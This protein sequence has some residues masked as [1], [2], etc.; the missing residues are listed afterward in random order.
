MRR[1]SA[2]AIAREALRGH[3]GWQRAWASPPEPKRRYKAIVVGGG[4]HG[5]A[6]GLLS[7]PQPRHHG[8]GDHREGMDRRRQHRAQHHHH[9]LELPPGRLRR[10]LREGPLALRD[11]EPGTQLQRHVQPPRRHDAGPDPARGPRLQAHRHGQRAAGRGDRVRRARAGEGAVPHHPH[12]GAALPRAGR[13][14]AAQGRHRAP[15]RGGLGLR[16]GLLGDGHGHRGELRGHR[17]ADL[18]RPRDGRRDDQG[19]RGVRQARRLRRGSFGR[20]RGDG[21]LPVA[22]RVAWRSRRWSRSRSSP[23]WTWW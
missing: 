8:R 1:Y 2:F 14:M 23:A 3:R 11:A 6:T 19:P 17:R 15:R 13:A 20:D 9:P 10:A 7:R 21:G 12:R 22:D 18:E 5:L 16:A 4:G